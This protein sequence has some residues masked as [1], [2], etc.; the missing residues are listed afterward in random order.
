[1]IEGPGN[2]GPREHGW[3]IW[4][5]GPW[6]PRASGTLDL[7]NM[8]GASGIEGPGNLGPREQ[9]VLGTSGNSQLVHRIS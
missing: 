2:L 8:D 6:K 7:G 3:S 9:W 5:R 4:N 1:M